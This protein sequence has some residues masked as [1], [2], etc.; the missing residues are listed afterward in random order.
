MKLVVTEHEAWRLMGLAVKGRFAVAE[1]AFPRQLN[2]Y[3]SYVG[4]PF[5]TMRLVLALGAEH[6]RGA[7]AVPAV[8]DV[9]MVIPEVMCMGAGVGVQQVVRRLRAWRWERVG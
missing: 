3:V 6:G 9:V 8:G 4:Q 1:V 7:W 2:G 5:E